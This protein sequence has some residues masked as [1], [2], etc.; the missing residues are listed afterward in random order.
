MSCSVEPINH[1]ILLDICNVY[2]FVYIPKNYLKIIKRKTFCTQPRKL[3]KLA[4][5]RMTVQDLFS[6]LISKSIISIIF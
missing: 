3:A 5:D 6:P 2:G 1:A 4:F